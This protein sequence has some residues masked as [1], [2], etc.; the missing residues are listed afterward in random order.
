LAD[1]EL[2]LDADSAYLPTQD[3]RD[4]GSNLE[5]HGQASLDASQLDGLAAG[6]PRVTL[7]T[8]RS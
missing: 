1:I 7:K 2:E 6:N 5:W 3:L 8:E 4:H